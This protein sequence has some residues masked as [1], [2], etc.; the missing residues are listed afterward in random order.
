MGEQVIE[1][2]AKPGA[3]HDGLTGQEKEDFQKLDL[4]PGIPFQ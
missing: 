1:W 4:F 2:F 3:F